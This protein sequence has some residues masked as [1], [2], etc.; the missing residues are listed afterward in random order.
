MAE[1]SGVSGILGAEPETPVECSVPEAGLD[2]TAAALVAVA[3]KSEADNFR[4]AD[5]SETNLVVYQ[6]RKENR[7]APLVA[8]L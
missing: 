5:H 6:P 7:N 8:D 2:P 3:A 4:V 1:S